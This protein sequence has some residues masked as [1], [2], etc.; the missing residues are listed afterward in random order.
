MT[1]S[2]DVMY[3]KL[4]KNQTTIAQYESE[5]RGY[6][7]QISELRKQKQS[8]EVLQAGCRQQDNEQYKISETESLNKINSKIVAGFMLE[9]RIYS[10]DCSN[11]RECIWWSG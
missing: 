5:I 3:V 7:Q 8:W 1:K 6:Q 2:E 4:C 10:P 11:I 9:C